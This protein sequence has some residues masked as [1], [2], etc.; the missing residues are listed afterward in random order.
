[1]EVVHS[2]TN[3]PGVKGAEDTGGVPKEESYPWLIKRRERGS[4]TAF[5]AYISLILY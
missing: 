4:T 5:A 2:G 3:H 1:M